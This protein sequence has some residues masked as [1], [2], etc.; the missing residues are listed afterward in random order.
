VDLHPLDPVDLECD[1]GE[2]RGRL[3]RETAADGVGADPVADLARVAVQPRVQAGAADDAAS[4]GSKMPYTASSPRAKSSANRA[5]SCRFCSSVVGSDS[6]QGI[7]GRRWSRLVSMASFASPASA[8][9]QQRITSRVVSMRKA[10]LPP[11]CIRSG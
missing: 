9:S 7:H 11:D 8:G 2:R 4:S 1:P 6:A 10:L 5:S 3:A